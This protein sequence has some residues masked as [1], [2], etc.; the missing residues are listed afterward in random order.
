VKVT[1]EGVYLPLTKGE[2]VSIEAMAQ[3]GLAARAKAA[4]PLGQDMPAQERAPIDRLVSDLAMDLERIGSAI[5]KLETR[6][7]S[8]LAE[9]PP[10]PEPPTPDRPGSSGLAH[11]LWEVRRMADA[12][13]DAL[14]R[15]M[16][17]LE[18]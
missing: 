16:N 13:A 1:W 11:A 14:S 4:Y 8:V 18:V 15:I 3:Q 6:L 17:R 12:Q 9:Q 7:T 10:F 5:I 2:R